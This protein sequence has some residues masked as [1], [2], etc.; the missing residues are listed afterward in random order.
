M[1]LALQAKFSGYLGR[2]S[3]RSFM[4][5]G[6]GLWALEDQ[7]LTRK[8]RGVSV[9]VQPSG[10]ASKYMVAEVVGAL[11]DDPGF[12]RTVDG[13]HLVRGF[14]IREVF[15]RFGGPFKV[16]LINYPGRARSIW[17]SEQVQVSCPSMV[18]MLDDG[19]NEEVEFKAKFMGYKCEVFGDWLL[20]SKGVE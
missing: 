3:P 11:T 1:T 20:M 10:L 6:D 19:H 15:D 2:L 5:F 7:L 16:F 12:I 9:R 4:T 14:T 18:V 17:Y 8:W 13:Q